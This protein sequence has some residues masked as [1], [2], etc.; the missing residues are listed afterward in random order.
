MK[1]DKN[2]IISVQART[3]STRFPGKVLE[4]LGKYTVLEYM[5]RRLKKS[6][7]TKT[8]VIATTTEKADE[9]IVKIA[10]RSGCAHF[11]GS[12]QDVLQR[13]CRSAQSVKADIIVHTTSDCPMIDAGLIDEALKV[14]LKGGYDNVGVGMNKS[15]PHGLDFFIIS[16][17]LLKEMDRKA[18]TPDRREHVI[19]YVTSQPEKFKCLYLEA[20]AGLSRPDVRITVD[21]KEDLANL[22]QIVEK[23]GQDNFDYSVKDIIKAW[24]AIKVQRPAALK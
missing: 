12:E 1:M 10:E 19:D 9:G 23:L 13:V 7:L 6:K 2:I 14:F 17:D 24:D 20:P 4:R 3:G 15:Y 11:R 5:V 18:D 21:Y 8:I 22:N 16:I